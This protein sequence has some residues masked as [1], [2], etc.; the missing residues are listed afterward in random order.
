MAKRTRTSRA[1]IGTPAR[2]ERRKPRDGIVRTS[3]YLP[4]D[5]YEGLRNAAFEGR[6]KMHDIILEGIEM[7]VRKRGRRTERQGLSVTRRRVAL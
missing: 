1:G 5:L 3:L 4:D 6:V 7:A 2:A